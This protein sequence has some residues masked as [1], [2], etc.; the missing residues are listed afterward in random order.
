MQQAI[1]I[2][3]GKFGGESFLQTKA[4]EVSE[5]D[6]SKRAHAS[7]MLRR[8]SREF[9]SFGLMQVAT[10]AQ[11]DPFVKVRGMIKEMVGGLF[12]TRGTSSTSCSCPC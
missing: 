6:F 10:A 1:D 2:L 4:V 3:G 5:S 9:N 8:L 12:T 11:D 7:S